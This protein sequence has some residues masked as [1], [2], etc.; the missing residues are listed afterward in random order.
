MK[1]NPSSQHTHGPVDGSLYATILKSP[2]SLQTSPVKPLRTSTQSLISPPAEFSSTNQAK[3]VIDT[4]D[5][6]AKYHTVGHHPLSTST[7]Q[8]HSYG[9]E[10]NS[11]GLY[12]DIKVI[13][14]EQRT[15]AR[16]TPTPSVVS[17]SSRHSVQQQQQSSSRSQQP[18]GTYNGFNGH[19]PD[20]SGGYA[21]VIQQHSSHQNNQVQGAEQREFVRSPLTL[22]MDSGISSS[23]VVNRG[24]RGVQGASSVSPV[25]FPSQASPQEDRHR[26]LDDLLSDMLM[27][28]QDIP[29]IQRST[30]VTKSQTHSRGIA[31]IPTAASS[32]TSSVTT[33]VTQKSTTSTTGNQQIQL[34]GELY[35][36]S[37]TTTLT[38][39]ASENGR[40]TPTVQLR[41]KRDLEQQERELIMSLSNNELCVN[42]QQENQQQ[43]A[44]N[45]LLKMNLQHHSYL[46]PQ[47]AR[48]ETLSISDTDDDQQSNIPYHAR[49][50]SR[51]FTYGNIPP[52]NS[53]VS[54]RTTPTVATTSSNGTMLKSQS[55]LS[56]PSMVRKVIIADKKQQQQQKPRNEFE[57][58]LMERREKIMSEKYSIGD[59]TPN[60][61]NPNTNGYD[62]KWY[63]TSS[64]SQTTNGYPYDLLK[65]S[66]TLDGSS[67]R[68]GV[69]CRLT[70]QGNQ[71]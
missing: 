16:N 22:S 1:V 70:Q 30:Q 60:G 31:P 51:P 71:L 3:Y 11:S 27:T 12:E 32:S 49:E 19:V 20:G 29:D 17:Y 50:D 66:N 61:S 4:P 68:L 58:M 69:S 25:S 54:G 18:N 41:N 37:S 35:E 38:P 44:G 52:P 39:P 7:P 5:S 42:E 53:T 2:K 26:E 67:F 56:S 62:S 15:S 59:K 10:S 57:D 8:V 14:Q 33:V 23:G 55:G 13:Q 63:H 46:Y 34:R 21:T 43:D 40:D 48:I 36:N 65:R 47:Q 9:K 6:G 24:G 28:V 45:T 64:T